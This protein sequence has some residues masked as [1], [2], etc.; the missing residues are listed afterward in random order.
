MA[1]AVMKNKKEIRALRALSQKEARS[2]RSDLEQLILICTT[3]ARGSSTR[4]RLRLIKRI[5]DRYENNPQGLVGA[6]M[7]LDEAGVKI[8][9]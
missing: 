9:L 5:R 8:K 1:E 6:Q 7:A 3:K 4:E 2:K